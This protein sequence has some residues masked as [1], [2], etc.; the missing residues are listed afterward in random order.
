MQELAA[1]NKPE[2]PLLN[3]APHKRGLVE[4]IFSLYIL[5]GLNYAIPM[6][7]LPYL[8]R[9]LGMEMY[10]LLAFTQS[11]AQYFTLF[12]DYGFNFSATRAIAQENGNHEKL[13]RI[14]CAVMLIKLALSLVGTVVLLII[15]HAVPRF[16]ENQ[17]FFLVAYA[18]VLGSV[19]FPT[20]F[21]QGLQQMRYV[22]AVIGFSRVI[23]TAAL[24]VFV[25]RPEDGLLA[26]S[27]QS[28]TVLGGGLAGM[29]I[30]FRNFHLHIRKPTIEDLTIAV[31]DGWHLFVSTAAV[32]LYTNTNVFLVGLLAGNLEAG[33]FSA[34]EK[35][36]RAIQGL[37]GPINQAIFP[38]VNS[39]MTKSREDAL[40]FA[41][42]AMRWTGSISWVGSA[43][44]FLLAPYV[45][46]L[47]F[48]HQAVG[49]LGVIRWIAFIPFLVAVSNV[50]G[51]QVMVTFGF[52]KQ[53]SRILIMAGIF[54][55]S[56]AVPLVKLYAAVGA[57]AS[58]FLT[59]VL[60]TV[61]M[62]VVLQRHGI[63]IWTRT[64]ERA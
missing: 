10:G 21:F 58:V 55:L 57:G 12:T 48:G 60:V 26:L 54:N 50:L 30:A 15:V 36:I 52:D 44:L 14:F 18:A 64:G 6:L 8:V 4:N 11:F 31:R 37:I 62:I 20:W 51:I 42:K 63:Y 32:S 40:E 27:I 56:L 1:S 29:W 16:Q 39:L 34:A 23:G 33:Y 53:F 47:L 5:Q 59:E 38:H 17:S 41:R 19:F 7:V 35:M 49:S 61:V 24:F 2:A 28:L 13:S 9:T 25:H 22:S 45:V 46:T 3:T 43:L